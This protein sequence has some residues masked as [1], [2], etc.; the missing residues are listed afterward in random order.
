[1]EDKE[2]DKMIKMVWKEKERIEGDR[3][4]RRR[5]NGQNQIEIID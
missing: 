2:E 5:K 1:M 3:I 4:D